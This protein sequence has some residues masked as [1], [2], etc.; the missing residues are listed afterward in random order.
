MVAMVKKAASKMGQREMV[1]TIVGVAACT[2]LGANGG[3]DIVVGSIAAM[4]GAY[5]VSRGLAKT[6]NK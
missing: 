4:T 6:E 5:S 1:L 2:Y 3:S